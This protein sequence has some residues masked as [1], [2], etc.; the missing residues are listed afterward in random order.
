MGI[1]RLLAE[2]GKR[3]RGKIKMHFFSHK[4]AKVTFAYRCIDFSP[5]VTRKTATVARKTATVARKTTTVARKTATVARETAT[6]MKETATVARKTTTVTRKTATVVR[7]TAT[8]ARKTATVARKT[9]T[10][11]RKTATVA[12]KTATVTRETTSSVICNVKKVFAKKLGFLPDKENRV[13]TAEFKY[14]NHICY[15]GARPC[16]PTAWSIYLKIAVILDKVE[17]RGCL[18]SDK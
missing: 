10:V 1:I 12:R 7:K 16:A 4:S 2:I 18:K 6:V 15:R 17:L 13:L 9:A 8:V 3:V 14:L 11:A 5:I